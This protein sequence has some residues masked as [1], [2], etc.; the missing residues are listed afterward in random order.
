MGTMGDV[1]FSGPEGSLRPFV[2]V[3][4]GIADHI[5]FGP[6]K[7]RLMEAVERTGSLQ[8]ACKDMGLSY[9]KGSR[10]IKNTEKQLGIR[11]VERWTGGNGGGGSRLTP[12]GK[13]LLA[14]YQELCR[15]VQADTE[16]AFPE[17]FG[18]AGSPEKE[19]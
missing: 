5:F 18:N 2:Q 1:V 14:R 19:T 17:Y 10:M 13:N 4:L 8:E 16:E 3:R 15:R 9:S 6:G 11:L 12:E 7:A